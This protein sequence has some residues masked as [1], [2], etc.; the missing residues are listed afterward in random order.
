MDSRSLK[1]HLDS[2]Y[3]KFDIK[4]LSPDP[5]ELVHK[6][7]SPEDKEVT[8]L[9][10]SSLAYGRVEKILSSVETIFSIM[11]NRPY[12]FTKKF[13]PKKD[14]K[15][16]KKFVHRFNIGE[17]VACLIYMMKQ[18][19]DAHGSLGDFFKKGYNRKDENI[20]PALSKF[21][22][23]MLALDCSPFYK[24]SNLPEDAGV[25][26]FLPSPEKGSACKRLNLYLRWMVRKGDKLDFGLW[27]G[28]PPSKLIIPLDT[29]IAKISRNLGLTKSKNPGWKMAIE[30]TASLKKLDPKDPVKYDFPLSR[31]G[32]MNLC[33]GK[34]DTEKCGKCGLFPIC[35]PSI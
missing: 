1:K 30:I 27:K 19:L 24:G 32:I 11:D 18:T 33:T 7:S 15:K 5:L 16:F 29:H 20:A 14:K 17:D 35:S 28:I 12:A 31:L 2:L 3:K 34:K 8:G 22:K 23:G 21:V 25:R 13:D 4:F 9:I 26:Y 10:A 6:F